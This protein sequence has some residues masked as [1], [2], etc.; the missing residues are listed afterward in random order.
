L[1]RPRR[2][3]ADNIKVDLGEIRWCR[4][5]WIGVAQDRDGWRTLV[6][7]VVDLRVAE[8]AWKLRD[9]CR[10]GGVWSSEQPLPAD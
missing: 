10:I 1:G 8:R 7:T 5:E 4:V 9:S 6:R 3:W 2:R